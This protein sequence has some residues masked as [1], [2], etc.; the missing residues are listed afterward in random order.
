MRR[1]LRNAFLGLTACLAAGVLA[2]FLWLP[3]RPFEA[4][5]GPLDA[6]VPRG[7]EAVLRCDAGALRRSPALRAM[8]EGP[9]GE[10]LRDA[11]N[12]E[13]PLALLRDVDAALADLPTAGGGAPTV[14]GDL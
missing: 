12:L 3:W 14:A 11:A 10:R 13:T 7:V 4:A 8:W 6:W 5:A 2:L 9:A 1:A